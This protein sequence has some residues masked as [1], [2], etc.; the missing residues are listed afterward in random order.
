MPAS[1]SRIEQYR[2]VHPGETFYSTVEVRESQAHRLLTDITAHDEA[3]RVWAQG[4]GVELILKPSDAGTGAAVT[5]DY[6]AASG[7][8][9]ARFTLPLAREDVHDHS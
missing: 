7:V 3:G 4:Q 1:C 6:H 5:G 8:A 9:G 2:D